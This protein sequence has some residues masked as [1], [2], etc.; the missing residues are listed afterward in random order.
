M[1]C[2]VSCVSVCV[3]CGMR[4]CKPVSLAAAYPL[5]TDGN[6]TPCCI[7]CIRLTWLSWLIFKAQLERHTLILTRP[8]PFTSTKWR[9]PLCM[10]SSFS[11]CCCCCWSAA[12]CTPSQAI[13][14]SRVTAT[15]QRAGSCNSIY[16]QV[17]II[18]P[19]QF[20]TGVAF[21]ALCACWGNMI[22]A[23]F[24]QHIYFKYQFMPYIESNYPCCYRYSRCLWSHS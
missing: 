7:V 20:S 24:M 21:R 3:A 11:C 17:T 6:F 10:P 9:Q 8:S 14:L 4:R 19:V 1:R 5:P 13:R 23:S 2:Q 22:L 16:R 15:K 18:C 12:D